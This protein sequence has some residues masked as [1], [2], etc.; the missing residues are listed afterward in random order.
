LKKKSQINID[1]SEAL[2]MT[3]L[4]TPNSSQMTNDTQAKKETFDP[5]KKSK[6]GTK[7]RFKNSS[8]VELS[9]L[10]AWALWRW[11]TLLQRIANE[12]NREH[13]EL[14]TE[15]RKLERNPM[16]EVTIKVSPVIGEL[17]H[18]KRKRSTGDLEKPT[19]VLELVLL[20]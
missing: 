17:A 5:Y 19:G 9:S 14:A 4:L 18:L 12:R 3:T 11:D 10:Q 1:Y 7:C 20:R 15:R 13:I 16:K 6:N 8:S 2:N